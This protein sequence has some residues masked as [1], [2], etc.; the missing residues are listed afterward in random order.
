MRPLLKFLETESIVVS[1]I[2]WS[3]RDVRNQFSVLYRLQNSRIFSL[4][5]PGVV[6]VVVVAG[7]GGIVSFRV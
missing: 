4:N 7:G 5:R 2:T 1:L 3:S 6:V